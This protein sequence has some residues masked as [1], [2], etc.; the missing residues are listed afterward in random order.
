MFMKNAFLEVLGETGEAKENET[1]PTAS[2]I[3]SESLIKL[4]SQRF[5]NKT[6]NKY[7]IEHY[8]DDLRA[9]AFQFVETTSL[10][11]LP[12]AYQ[13]Q[14]ID[15]DIGIICWRYP[16]PRA[17]QKIK[18]F[19]V[20]FQAI[21]RVEITCKLE[22]YSTLK[23]CFEEFCQFS[24][25]ENE[26]KMLD[27]KNT[28]LCSEIW[29]IKIPKVCLK[30]DSDFEDDEDDG[31][32]YEFRMH[33][34]VLVACLRIDSYFATSIIPD[35][36][37][38]IDIKNFEV[39]LLNNIKNSDLKKMDESM[40]ETLK[41]F[42]L[43]D[44]R[45]HQHVFLRSQLSHLRILGLLMDENY[46]SFE[47]ESYLSSQIVDYGSMNFVA[48][49][50]P[51]CA[52]ML[53]DLNHEETN[54]NF[55]IDKIPI[56]FSAGIGHALLI[57]KLLWERNLQVRDSLKVPELILH[58]KY[59]ICNNT[60]FPIIFGQHNTNETICLMPWAC[61]LY[62]FKSEKLEQKIHVAICEKNEWS[63]KSGPVAVNRENTEFL[64][65]ID[66]QYFIISIKSISSTQKKV[67]I[68]GQVQIFNMSKETFRVIYKVYDKTI[69]NAEKCE[70]REFELRGKSNISVFGK[71]FNYSEHS[72][73]L[74]IAQFKSGRYSGEIPLKEIRKPWVVKGELFVG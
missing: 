38:F 67:L 66:N 55:L 32:E 48:L 40:P 73:R 27:L 25:T 47:I 3:P 14:I 46:Q 21:N 37:V 17:L 54:L 28:R 41:S 1:S 68:N 43:S 29:R 74:K 6:R 18:I 5:L 49:V 10:K 11:D 52:K 24:L 62:S 9:G 16:Q 53:V 22:Y 7:L 44:D 65:L 58:T 45:V 12:L 61:S 26:T 72:M 33:P 8:Q 34:K 42:H 56:K 36:D 15:Q 35:F 63:E 31:D 13:I 30:R 71:C 4:S 39:N 69:E 51:F 50:D 59:V 20:P 70:A 23:N 64:H 19:P 2:P 57:S 60:I